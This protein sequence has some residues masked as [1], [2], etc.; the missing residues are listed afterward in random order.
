MHR[1][2]RWLQYPRRQWRI[3]L[4]SLWLTAG[5]AVVTAFQ[6]WPLKLLVDYGLGDRAAPARLRALVTVLG[7]A[8]S[9]PVWIGLAALASLGL[10][11][12]TKILQVAQ[13]WLWTLASQRMVY[14]LAA[15]LFHRYQRLSLMFHMRRRVGDLLTRLTSDTWA[16][17]AVT[18]TVLIAPARHGFILVSVGWVAWRLNPTL[19][20]VAFAVAPLLAVGVRFWGRVLKRRAEASRE[21]RATLQNFVHQTLG[22]IPLVQVFG[23][24][25]R[26]REQ[27]DRLAGDARTSAQREAV[28][29]NMLT[30]LSGVVLAV[31]SGLV[32]WVGSQEV[33]AH[34]LTLGG[35]LVFIGY[36]RPLQQSFQGLLENYGQRQ[37]AKVGLARVQ[38]VLEAA[39]DVPEAPAARPFPAPTDRPRG[40][41]RIEDVTFGYEP[42][43]PVLHNISLEARP[44]EVIALVGPT[45]AGKTTLAMLI[46]R[47]FDPVSGRVT[48][49]GVDLRQ[50]QL[51]S[52]REHVSVVLQEPFLLPL[53][54]GQNIAYGRPGA[55]QEEIVVAAQLALAD[56]FI[57]QLP[58]GYDTVLGERGTTLSGGQRQRVAIARALLKNAPVL[59]LDEPSSALDTPTET[60]IMTALGRLIQGRTTFI[61]AHRFSTIQHATRIAVLANGR[62]VESGT[63]TELLARRGLYYDLYS[64]QTASGGVEVSP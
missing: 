27:F 51:R 31:G 49:D 46:P 21:S 62:L 35:L 34:R 37:G 15:D 4:A 60:Q 48:V 10:F 38:E 41:I 2:G 7:L 59:V 47:L 40:H 30:A 52:L 39:D 16:V 36:L 17:A 55:S 19:T 22:A 9:P 42:D 5:L 29:K 8:P 3:L 23:L 64:R 20:V 45:G 28:A 25:P 58:A 18:D 63:A 54:V 11:A 57:R 14:D 56:E 13:V 6:P 33:L 32:L 24:A 50:L 53:T 43:R 1:S 44:G 12:L 61:I 26:N